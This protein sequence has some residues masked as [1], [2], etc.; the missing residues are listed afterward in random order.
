VPARL[1]VDIGAVRTI[2]NKSEEFLL[3]A[4]EKN[5]PN[6]IDVEDILLY[7]ILSS[8]KKKNMIY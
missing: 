1:M 3:V 4:V 7:Y 8:F 6:H 5:V 2:N